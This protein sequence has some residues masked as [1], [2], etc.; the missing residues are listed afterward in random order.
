[1]F[2][3]LATVFAA[4]DMAK[5]HFCVGVDRVRNYA[6]VAGLPR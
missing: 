5:S 3:H 4:P 6:S 2:D 1:L